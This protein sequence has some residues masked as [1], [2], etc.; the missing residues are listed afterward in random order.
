MP[1]TRKILGQAALVA[2]VLTNVY[3]V[4]ASTQTVV[5]TIAVTNRGAVQSFFSVS[6]AKTGAADD[7]KQYIYFDV[8]ILPSD[9]FCTTIGITLSTGDIIRGYGQS[10][11]LSINIFGVEIT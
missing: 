5:S 1:E 7:P 2:T 10:S 8:P 11:D 6:V 3:T 9:T 4:P